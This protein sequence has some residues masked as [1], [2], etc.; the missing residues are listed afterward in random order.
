MGTSGHV[1]APIGTRI[2]PFSPASARCFL[3]SLH[4]IFSRFSGSEGVDRFLDF[5]ASICSNLRLPTRAPLLITT[6]HPPWQR[7]PCH[8]HITSQ[9]PN[10]TSLL[11]T[12][13]CH[14]RCHWRFSPGSLLIPPSPNASQT[15]FPRSH[16]SP[17]KTS[18]PE[19][20]CKY[21]RFSSFF[22]SISVLFGDFLS[23]L[24][25]TL[26]LLHGLLCGLGTSLSPSPC[27]T[28]LIFLQILPNLRTDRA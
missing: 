21:R 11:V 20:K 1:S 12:Q 13:G 25:A 7:H 28:P 10:P 24:L 17:P 2:P 5:K 15:L 26:V 19:S 23:A 14:R 4:P 3:P 16:P 27:C 18:H 6:S 9:N 8:V 22:I